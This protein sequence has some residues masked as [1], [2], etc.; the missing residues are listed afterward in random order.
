MRVQVVSRSESVRWRRMPSGFENPGIYR[1]TLSWQ[2]VLGGAGFRPPSVGNPVARQPRCGKPS[3]CVPPRS[4]RPPNLAP[5][6]GAHL[7]GLGRCR[8]AEKRKR[9]DRIDDDSV[10]G[11]SQVFPQAGWLWLGGPIRPPFFLEAEA[12]AQLFPVA[13]GALDFLLCWFQTFSCWLI[14]EFNLAGAMLPGKKR[15]PWW[16]WKTFLETRVDEFHFAPV[17]R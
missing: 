17:D 14:G 7:E 8:G 15:E 11:W 5:R 12:G 2:G 4:N 13:T 3:I 9:I 16:L 10:G 1:G 6:F